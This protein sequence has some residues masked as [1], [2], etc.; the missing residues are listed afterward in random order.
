MHLNITAKPG[1]EIQLSAKGTTDPDGDEL[2][3]SWWQYKEAGTYPGSVTIDNPTDQE[4]SFTVPAD[5]EKGQTIHIVCE[6]KDSGNPAINKLQESYR[7]C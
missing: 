6:V 7:K 3:Y 4:A 5:A 1:S 2:S